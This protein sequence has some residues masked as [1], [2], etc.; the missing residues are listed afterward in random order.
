MIKV[1]R[2]IY[3]LYLYKKGLL[4]IV[5]QSVAIVQQSCIPN[6]ELTTQS[7]EKRGWKPEPVIWYRMIQIVNNKVHTTMQACQY[8]SSEDPDSNPGALNIL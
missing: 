4:Y 6:K 3:N 5:Q 1:C 2:Y 8:S 7:S